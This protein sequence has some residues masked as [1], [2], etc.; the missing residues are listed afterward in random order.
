MYTV[1]MLCAGLHVVAMADK[2]LHSR[3]KEPDPSEQIIDGFA[4]HAMLGF[5]LLFGVDLLKIVRVLID[6]GLKLFDRRLC[7]LDLIIGRTFP[8]GFCRVLPFRG[9]KSGLLNRIRLRIFLYFGQF[10]EAS[11]YEIVKV[12]RKC[13]GLLLLLL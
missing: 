13:H 6:V 2:R 10:I 5:L 1:I 7:F 12:F 11:C 4:I 8:D 9:Q 3:A